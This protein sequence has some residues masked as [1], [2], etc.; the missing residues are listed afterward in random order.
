MTA[1]QGFAVE[2]WPTLSLLVLTGV[3]AIRLVDAKRGVC[4]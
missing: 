1:L 4:V 2:K 3:A